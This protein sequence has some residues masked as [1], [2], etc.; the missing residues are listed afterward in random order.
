V[1]PIPVVAYDHQ[2]FS[3][4]R[5]GG[6]SRYITE[7]AAR[8]P[9]VAPVDTWIVAPLH[10]NATLAASPSRKL[11]IAKEFNFPHAQAARAVVNRSL[12][13]LAMRAIRPSLVHW[14]Y[15]NPGPLP[16]SAVSVVTVYD[17]VHELFPDEFNPRD[18]TRE[19]KR[20]AVARAEHVICISHNTK[21]DLIKLL[22]VPGDK[23]SVTHLGYSNVF[24][25]AEDENVAENGNY[26]LYVGQRN[27]YKGF[28]DAIRAFASSNRLKRD[29]TFVAFG[30]APFQ[31]AELDLFRSLGLGE[32]S[33][34]H[35]VGNDEALARLYRSA[36]L[37]VYP[38]KYEGFGIPPLEAMACGCPVACANNSSIPEVVGKAALLFDPDDLDAMRDSFEIGCLNDARRAELIQ[39]GLQRSALFSWDQCARE[40]ASIYT[41]AI[42]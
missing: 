28:N 24:K 7:L 25:L 1:K 39:A 27:R 15:F 36:R 32:R 5:F 8:I 35:M 10:I 18:S 4:Q 37:F 41:R 11:G 19:N 30:G 23:I 6:V 20:L 34:R 9:I 12:S 26:V 22:G 42:G 2:I 29:F 14:T 33:V 13:Y 16:R 40:T 3:Y 17:M 21:A 31:A 38:S